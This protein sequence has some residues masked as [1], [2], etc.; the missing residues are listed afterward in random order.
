MKV[1][2]DIIKLIIIDLIFL[3]IILLFNFDLILGSA[4]IVVINIFFYCLQNLNSRSILLS[5]FISYFTVLMGR[6]VIEYF[7]NYKVEYFAENINQ[8]TNVLLLTS[9]ISIFISYYFLSKLTP[10]DESITNSYGN[11]T[12]INRIQIVT[13][14]LSI[15]SILLSIM[16]SI[17]VGIYVRNVGYADTYTLDFANYLGNNVFFLMLDKIQQM[18][19]VFISMFYATMPT[20]KLCK[21]PTLLYSIYLCS[22]ILSGQRSTVVLGFLWIFIY[23]SYRNKVDT[24]TIWISKK[25][26]KWI[27]CMLPAAVV[28][29]SLLSSLREGRIPSVSNISEELISFFYQQG[30]SV[31]VIKRSYQY[32][33]LLPE[34]KYYSLEFFTTGILGK[35]FGF[36]PYVGNNI[37]HARYGYSLAHALSFITMK[38]QYLLGRGTGT[39]YIAE[40]YHDFGYVGVIIGNIFY[41]FLLYR[42]S[43]LQ[44]KTYFVTVFKLLIIQELLWSPRGGFSDFL[45]LLFRPA[46]LIAVI[47][48][49]VLSLIIYEKEGVMSKNSVY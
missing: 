40:L 36:Y 20:R 27:V 21:L 2:K 45:I 47:I 25:T 10:G 48:V 22:T 16:Y 35:I 8:H 17:I 4:C 30:V 15:I 7:F 49:I 42:T 1:K 46:T 34:D 26:I 44:N 14:Y 43:I 23:Y 37:E 9:A 29:L 33:F 31:N 12:F 28:S 24:N 32:S 5:F 39:S 41:G 6:Q 13:Y 18:V 19:I 38:A 3:M 11:I